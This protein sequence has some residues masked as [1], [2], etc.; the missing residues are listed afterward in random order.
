[1]GR[2]DVAQL[3]PVVAVVDPA[4]SELIPLQKV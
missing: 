3:V 2:V 1:M 4:S